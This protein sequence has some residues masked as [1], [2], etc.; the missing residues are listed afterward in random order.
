MERRE[1][2]SGC[3][4][5]TMALF[6]FQLLLFTLWEL[7]LLCTNFVNILIMIASSACLNMYGKRYICR[8][9]PVDILSILH[10][11]P[12]THFNLFHSGPLC[13]WPTDQIQTPATVDFCSA[14]SS[15][16]LTL[17]HNICSIKQQKIS[18]TGHKCTQMSTVSLLICWRFFTHPVRHR[19]V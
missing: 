15:G 18:F 2:W 7:A 3:W 4:L 10:P 11:N 1:M 19:P 12:L 13:P 17:S 8:Y 16:I 14:V 9:T 5:S 6:T